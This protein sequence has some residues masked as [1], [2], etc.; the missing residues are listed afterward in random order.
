MT[1]PKLPYCVFV[2]LVC[3]FWK[4]KKIE[5]RKFY[6]KLNSDVFLAL[7]INLWKLKNKIS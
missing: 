4:L 1:F 3:H 5:F 7:F 6:I 2:H